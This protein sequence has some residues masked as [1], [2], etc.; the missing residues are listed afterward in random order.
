MDKT[1]LIGYSES[2]HKGQSLE[3]FLHGFLHLTSARMWPSAKQRQVWSGNSTT[4]SRLHH[5][6]GSDA[7]G[8][9]HFRTGDIPDGFEFAAATAAS[10]FG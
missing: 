8:A 6:A 3:K 1:P 2:R 5:E 10:G 4:G 9:F 7:P